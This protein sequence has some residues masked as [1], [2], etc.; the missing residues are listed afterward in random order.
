MERTCMEQKSAVIVTLK[1]GIKKSYQ[2][3]TQKQW[4]LSTFIYLLIWK[5]HNF[6]RY[7]IALH[8]VMAP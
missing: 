3:M 2:F 6:V 8:N 5:K 1:K 7:E 4:E